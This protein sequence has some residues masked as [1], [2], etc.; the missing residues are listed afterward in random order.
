MSQDSNLSIAFIGAGNMATSIIG[1]LIDNG[2]EGSILAADKDREKLADLKNRFGVSTTIDNKEAI[3]KADIIVL[4]VK[5]Q[6]MKMVCTEFSDQAQENKP[7]FISI[8]AGLESE[9]INQWLGGDLAIVRCMPNTPALLQ[10]GASGLFAN[11]LVSGSQKRIAQSIFDS[12]GTTVWVEDENMLHAVTAVSGS[13]PAYY[14]LFM[15]AMQ[16]A[17]ESLGLSPEISAQLT[18][19]T[20]LGAAKMVQQT[21]DSAETLR[22]KVTSP[23]GTTEKAIKS[24]EQD[25]IRQIIHQ[26]MLECVKRSEEL[27]QELAQ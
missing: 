24:F 22:Q 27:S 14:F 26:A 8:A 19:Q 23:N 18:A 13:G 7:M 11:H 12:V 6:I 17:G 9:T 2:F 10:A 1:G 21:D 3:S 25:G 16:K 15:E 5:P 4:A 20:A